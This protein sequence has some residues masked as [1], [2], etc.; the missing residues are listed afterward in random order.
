MTLSIKSS[1]GLAALQI[2]AALAATAAA[3]LEWI[4][5]EQATRAAMAVIG[6]ALA[7]MANGIPKAVDGRTADGQAIKRVTGWAFVLAGLA[8][9]AIWLLAPM[10][11]ANLASMAAVIAAMVWVGVYG[12]RRWRRSKAG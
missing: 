3:R 2:G 10:A 4:S 7:V 1:L 6:L 11:I 9:A 12:Y 8:H 5:N